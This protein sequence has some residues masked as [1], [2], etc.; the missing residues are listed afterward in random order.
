MFDIVVLM[1]LDDGDDEDE[2]EGSEPDVV[3]AAPYV[4]GD[5]VLSYVAPML[6]DLSRLA[7]SKGF[8]RL[9]Y[10]LD[11]ARLEADSLNNHSETPAT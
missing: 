8:G 6:A 3:G 11:I 7:E 9:A 10:L 1:S 5:E 2:G 4:E